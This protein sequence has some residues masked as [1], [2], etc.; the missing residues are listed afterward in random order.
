MSDTCASVLAT[1]GNRCP[2]SGD[3]EAMT[4]C[5]TCV[6]LTEGDLVPLLAGAPAYWRLKAAIA[7]LHAAG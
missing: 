3:W 5:R 1:S 6:R 4:T 7:N 2:A